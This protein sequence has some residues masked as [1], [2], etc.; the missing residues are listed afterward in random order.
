MEGQLYSEVESN[1]E[2]PSYATLLSKHFARQAQRQNTASSSGKSPSDE[3]RAASDS[4]KPMAHVALDSLHLR[5]G[6]LY[7][8]LHQGSCEH[9]WTITSLR[10]MSKG[11]MKRMEQGNLPPVTTFLAYGFMLR[12][13]VRWARPK[14]KIESY[15]LDNCE[16][17]QCRH[18]CLLILGGADFN[19]QAAKAEAVEARSKDMQEIFART[20]LPGLKDGNTS[21][22]EVCWNAMV[23]ARIPTLEETVQRAGKDEAA[24]MST[25]PWAGMHGP[26]WTVV[27]A[28]E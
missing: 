2:A 8:F 5:F 16:L 1:E 21:V 6:E 10:T 20:R 4:G 7:W 12:P 24:D 25:K 13:L 18:A 28:L 17:C 9:L 22:C 3:K 19:P 26:G 15:A 23:G 14:T 11:E 27:P